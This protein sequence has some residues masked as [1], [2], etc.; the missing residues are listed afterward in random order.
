MMVVVP[1]VVKNTKAR[2]ETQKNK[3]GIL[4][5]NF[6]V[7]ENERIQIAFVVV[8]WFTNQWW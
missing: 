3:I 5:S 8:S 4:R 1:K 7:N 6:R 2:V